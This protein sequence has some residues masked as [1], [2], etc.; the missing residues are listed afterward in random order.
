MMYP[1][2]T[3]ILLIL[4]FACV[5]TRP[6]GPELK[7]IIPLP[8]Q[9]DECSGMISL[10]NGLYAGLNDSGNASELYIFTLSDIPETRVVKI[11]GASNHDWEELTVDEN[12]VYISDT[13]NNSGNRKDLKI[14]RVAK[15]ALIDQDEAQAEVI[16]FYYPEQKKFEP[17]NKHNFDCEAMISSG[18][19]LYLFTK[20]R[21]NSKTDLYRIPKTPGNYPAKYIDR[22]D[23]MGLITGADFRQTPAKNSL[24]LIGYTVEGKGYHPFILYFQDVKGTSYLKGPFERMNFDGK[25]QTESI[26]FHDDQSVYITN[27]EEHG[28]KGFVYQVDIQK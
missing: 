25:L 4:S 8:A 19:S 22:F 17:S 1:A 27:E 21:G 3:L 11:T 14:Y 28:D 20:N 7:P 15:E 13:G 23:A 6:T 18:D 26:C 9:L 24:V 12:Y 16:F 2:N 5:S 10:G